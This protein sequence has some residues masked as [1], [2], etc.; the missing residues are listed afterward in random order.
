VIKIKR[1]KV[2][3]P[4]YVADSVFD[5]DITELQK[6]G[7]KYLI[8]DLDNTLII[9][10]PSSLPKKVAERIRNFRRAGFSI[11][12]GSNTRRNVD[13]IVKTMQA[14]TIRS[15]G[16]TFKPRK[17]FYRQVCLNEDVLPDTIAMIGDHIL[18]DV[19]GGNRA[20]LTT[21]LIKSLNNKPK[22]LN[23]LY[24]KHLLH[25]NNRP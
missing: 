2:W 25:A 10:K 5:V 8:F 15:Q 6:I 22:D 20:G 21:V 7:V 18:N 16:M 14:K 23:H 9:G 24:I 13:A 17:K 3:I 12:V 11:Y 4:D 1:S 19:I